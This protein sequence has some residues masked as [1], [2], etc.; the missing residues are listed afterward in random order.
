[1]GASG[2]GTSPTN[3][4]YQLPGGSAGKSNYY[5]ANG[6]LTSDV[7]SGTGHTYTWDS[8][9]NMISVD[10]STVTI[11]YDAFDCMIEQTRGSSH[12]EIVY[13]PGSM[14]LALMNGQNLVNAF[15]SV[16]GGGKAVY[17]STGL[18]YYRH[19]DHLGSSRLSTKTT[20]GL[21]WYQSA[22]A[23]YGEDYAQ[24]GDH[25][26]LSFT[27]Q[28]Q[29]TVAGGWATN[30][31]DFM[32]REYRPVQG[33]WTAP[34]PAGL[35]VV[36][37]SNPQSWNRYAY[38]LNNPM[39]LVDLLGDD[40][41]YFGSDGAGAINNSAMC[42]AVGGS[43]VVDG[44]S[45]CPFCLISVPSQPGCANN[46]CGP[47]P[48]PSGTC[49]NC[50]APAGPPVTGCTGTCG[51]TGQGGGGSNGGGNSQPTQPVQP[52]P[53]QAPKKPFYCGAGNSWS[54]PFTAPTTKQWAVWAAADGAIALG[55]TRRL[56][57][58]SKVVYVFASAAALETYLAVTCS[59]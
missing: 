55:L 26:D 56:G 53:Q 23:P 29:D 31:Y 27:G 10:G 59:D 41:C 43:W 44:Q 32:F 3:Q 14:K 25:P 6:N 30:L 40:G 24:G 4:Y 42:N 46:A 37:P 2:T 49:V 58:E 36:D 21:R 7:A 54:H 33:R 35:S 57:A 19:A 15:V 12:T 22:Y 28:N 45:S 48:N 13:G 50:V 38:V 8:D 34:D 39:A 16:P 20:Q 52:P 47:D 11:M 5:D 51:G 1:V 17:T 18:T 9:G